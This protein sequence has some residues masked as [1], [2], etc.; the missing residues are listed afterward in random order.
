MFRLSS[1]AHGGPSSRPYAV[2]PHTLSEILTT[3]SLTEAVV[4][5]RGQDLGAAA[6][7]QQ[8]EYKGKGMA[9]RTF[10]PRMLTKRLVTRS[11]LLLQ[12][13]GRKDEELNA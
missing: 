13:R 2:S 4:R 9:E 11:R 1:R 6:R 12:Q 7:Y 3:S 8:R 10:Q 5:V